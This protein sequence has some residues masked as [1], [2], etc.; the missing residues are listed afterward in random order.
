VDSP[1]RPRADTRDEAASDSL[2]LLARAQAGDRDALD[3]LLRR[4]LPRLKRWIGGRL[5]RHHRGLNDTEDLVQETLI[6]VLRVL[7]D[8]EIRHEAGLQAY[9]R[10]AVW[11]R[12]R[13]E[14]RRWTDRPVGAQ[15]DESLSA[16]EPSPLELAIGQQAIDRYEAALEELDEDERSAIVLR[17]EFGHSYPELAMMLEKRTPDAARKIVERALPKLAESMRRQRAAAGNVA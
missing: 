5:P 3:D 13:Q 14:I 4:Y 11:N 16:T 2:A 17:L 12:L 6:N 8:F 15:L 1:D 10:H 9:L 7:P